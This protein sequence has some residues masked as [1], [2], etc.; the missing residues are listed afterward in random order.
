[1]GIPKARSQLEA[2]QR[3]MAKAEGEAWESERESSA[4][5]GSKTSHTRRPRT[6]MAPSCGV[7]NEHTGWP[8]LESRDEDEDELCIHKVEANN[9]LLF[10]AAVN[11]LRS[12]AFGAHCGSEIQTS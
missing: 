4:E 10:L 12:T 3:A 11:E 1:M 6:Y 9:T 2:T 8:R 7:E 5:E